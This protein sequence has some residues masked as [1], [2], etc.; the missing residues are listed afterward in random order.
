V[1]S[2]QA[3]RPVRLSLIAFGGVVAGIILAASIV[4]AQ[5]FHDGGM[6]PGQDAH[7]YWLAL[8]GTPYDSGPGTYGAYLYSPAF[9]QALSQVLALAWPQFRALWTAMLMGVLLYLCGPVLFAVALP[10]AFFELW[11]GNIHLLLAL[12]IVVGFRHPA[13]WAFVL[14]TKVTP[15][16][17]LAWFAVRREWAHLTVAIALVVDPGAWLAWMDLLVGQSASAPPAGSI[18]IPLVVRL[19]LAL[20]A[21]AYAGATDRRWLVPVGVLL[22]MPVMW[23]G[24]LSLLFAAVALERGAL[25]RR[26]VDLV[27][28]LRAAP[29]R[30]LVAPVTWAIEPE[31]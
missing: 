11:G 10:F 15:G 29:Q 16:V 13:S 21:V 6:G 27:A 9:V 5:H 30:Q 26:L 2:D 12:A 8:R 1:S 20:A 24:G 28:Q 18:P 19:P 7:A 23:W 3:H 4:G 22:A 31:G 17:G 14:L 25:E